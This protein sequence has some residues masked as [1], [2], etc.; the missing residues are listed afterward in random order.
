MNGAAGLLEQRLAVRPDLL[1]G[2]AVLRGK[3]PT[4]LIKHPET[5]RS[6]E[7]GEREHFLISRLDGNHTLAQ[8]GD[9]Y[10][11]RFGK[12][13]GASAWQQLLGLLYARQL[14]SGVAAPAP[15][16]PPDGNRA[17]TNPDAANRRGRNTMWSG[18]V[19][20][21]GG[22]NAFVDRLNSAL[23]P[24]FSASVVVPVVL[25]VVGMQALIAL[26]PSGYL[27]E[28]GRTLHNLGLSL[29]VTAALWVSCGL[30]EL[31]HGVLAR[32]FGGTVTE[33]GVQWRLCI[34]LPYCR[35]EDY[36]YLRRRWHQVAV[37]GVGVLAN[38]SL[39][40]PVFLAH[41]LVAPGP[42]RDALGALILLGSITALANLIP[43][44]PTDGYKMLGHGLGLPDLAEHTQRYVWL[45]VQR[46]R[47]R[48][49]GAAGYPR[50]ARWAYTAYA[51]FTVILL[52]VVLAALAALGVA[53]FAPRIDAPLAA[54]VPIAALTACIVIGVGFRRRSLRRAI[55]SVAHR[56]PRA[57]AIP[58]RHRPEPRAHRRRSPASRPSPAEAI[59]LHDV[60][61]RYGAVTA[62]AGV[63][64]TVE[65][66][67]F[68]GLLGPNGAGKTTLVEIATG[69]RQADSG[70]VRVLGQSPWPRNLGLLP[71]LGV[72][73]QSSAFFLRLSAAEHLHTV[74]ALHGVGGRAVARALRTVG[75]SEHANVRVEALSGGQRQRLAIATAL[76]PD[77][78]VI[79]LDEPTAALDPQAR[80]D[81]WRI[82]R[83]LKASGRTVVYTTHHLDEA[84]A[85][86]D[87][88]AIVV[89][90]SV[91]ALDTPHNLARSRESGVQ[92]LVPAERLTV[93]QAR[94]LAGVDSAVLDRDHVVLHTSTA[95]SVLQQVDALAGLHGVR[96]RT[97]SLEDVY[98]ELAG[99]ER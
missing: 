77:P 27:R 14:L 13:I 92:L 82:L 31:A 99:S 98:L 61:K 75:M 68:F 3:A 17:D 6:F 36:L 66:G 65:R 97:T 49:E 60:R 26:D 72:Q 48:G 10:A 81:L 64:V 57:G 91:V 76:L 45:A 70:T 21:T 39:L 84:E 90:G 5:G 95:G 67:E 51:L 8:I 2:P 94:L 88:V 18:R 74:A 79:F 54:L 32:R 28:T 23:R 19:A 53:L 41:L 34:A 46:W 56:S 55:N 85:L 80:R 44:P 15:G 50:K 73:T 78:E 40:L 33:M 30:H 62:L 20:L 1:I 29:A 37:A 86:C 63:S 42:L 38:L 47:G 7:V 52:A 4:H 93:D 71:R 83:D 43:V 11:R 24:I 35:V 58:G 89:A 59:V 96:T 9:E 25:L 16:T 87:R 22:A 12:R 69:L